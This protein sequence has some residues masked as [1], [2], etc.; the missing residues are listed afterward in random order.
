M[1][2]K[3]KRLTC[4]DLAFALPSVTVHP[5]LI[6]NPFYFF[7]GIQRISYWSVQVFFF[8]VV[9]AVVLSAAARFRCTPA[10]RFFDLSVLLLHL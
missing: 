2:P 1:S 10:P 4:T 6:Q 8:V 5:E 3:I 7:F 9:A